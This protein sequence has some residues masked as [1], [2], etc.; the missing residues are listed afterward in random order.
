MLETD[1]EIQEL[2]ALID[3]TFARANEHLRNIAKPERRLNARQVV[4]YLQG[5]KHVAFATVNERGEPRVAPL[6][7]V[8]LHGR[9]TV[10]TGGKAARLRHL[11]ANPA[12]SAAHMDGDNVG[13]VVHGHATIIGRGGEGVDAIEPVWREIYGSSPFEWG[14]GVVFMRIEPTSMWTYAF[15]PENFP[16]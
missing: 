14:D 11:R 13:I 8:F 7:G 2:D 5:T 9:F 3:R 12:C 10:S 6:D 16:E 15:H 1:A 4:R